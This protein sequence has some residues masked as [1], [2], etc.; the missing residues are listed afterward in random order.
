MLGLGISLAG[1]AE[2]GFLAAI[3]VSMFPMQVR[4]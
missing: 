4:T 1:T 3:A 2:D